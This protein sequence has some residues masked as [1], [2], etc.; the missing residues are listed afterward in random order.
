MKLKEH[1]KKILLDK[2]TPRALLRA[3]NFESKNA[4]PYLTVQCDV[5]SIF[6]FP[7]CV[8]RESRTRMI[9][10]QYVV[11]GRETSFDVLPTNDIYLIDRG[12]FLQVSREHFQI[13]KHSEEYYLVDRG[14]HC[15]VYVNDKRLHGEGKLITE[16]LCDGDIIKIGTMESLY[17]FEFIVLK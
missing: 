9:D 5:I 13:E 1:D 15:G 14:S 12:E 4:I 8:G 16:K 10:E 11:I 7:F 6:K 2:Y 17:I 3:C